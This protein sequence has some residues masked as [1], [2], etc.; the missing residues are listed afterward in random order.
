MVVDHDEAVRAVLE[1]LQGLLSRNSHDKANR[2]ISMP[3]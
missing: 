3:F 1:Q 2:G